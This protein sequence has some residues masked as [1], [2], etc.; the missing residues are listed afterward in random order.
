MEPVEGELNDYHQG[1]SDAL[2]S[3]VE[4][5]KR[6]RAENLARWV[7]CSVEFTVMRAYYRGKTRTCVDILKGLGVDE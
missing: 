2:A 3:V 4:M 7:G 1:E 5:V 6:L